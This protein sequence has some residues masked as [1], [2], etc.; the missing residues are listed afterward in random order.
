MQLRRV[1]Y[2]FLQIGGAF[3]IHYPHSASK[4]RLE[5]ERADNIDWGQRKRARV[6]ALFLDF[7]KW[8]YVKVED[9]LRTPMCKD[10]QNDDYSL[11]VH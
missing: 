6:D 10:A 3:L 11:W 7:K 1:G 9:R 4:S 2:K 5:W 8:L